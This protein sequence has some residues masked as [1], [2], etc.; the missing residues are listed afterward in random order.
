MCGWVILGY[1]QW[2]MIRNCSAPQTAQN[3]VRFLSP[4]QELQNKRRRLYDRKRHLPCM[5]PKR[6]R[7]ISLKDRSMSVSIQRNMSNDFLNRALWVRY[8]FAALNFI[9]KLTD[10]K[11]PVNA[12]LFRYFHINCFVRFACVILRHSMITNNKAER[13]KE[14]IVSSTKSVIA[15]K[16]VLDM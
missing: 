9:H 11:P 1:I 10:W 13:C 5:C 4:L 16:R 14:H 2:R 7:L 3:N 6:I 12:I 15:G 8:M